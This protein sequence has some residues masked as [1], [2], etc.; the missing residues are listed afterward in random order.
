MPQQQPGQIYLTAPTPALLN[1][2]QGQFERI[3]QDGKQLIRYTLNC[4][5][6]TADTITVAIQMPLSWID[7]KD[8]DD[9]IQTISYLCSGNKHGAQAVKPQHEFNLKID[10]TA[11]PSFTEDGDKRWIHDQLPRVKPDADKKTQEKP[12]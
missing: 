9:K 7:T 1:E 5:G 4:G 8:P 12:A 3:E 2:Q 6:S 11:L 10:P